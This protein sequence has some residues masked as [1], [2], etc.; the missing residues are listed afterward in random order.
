MPQR[1]P[2]GHA[3][4]LHGRGPR[5]Y[6]PVARRLRRIL[7]DSNA[8]SAADVTPRWYC[9]AQAARP[10][11]R[12]RAVAASAA[13]SAAQDERCPVQRAPDSALLKD[14]HR[15]VAGAHA[16]RFARFPAT[17]PKNATADATQWSLPHRR[18]RTAS[19]SSKRF[20]GNWPTTLWRAA[21]TPPPRPMF[22][23]VNVTPAYARLHVSLDS[24]RRTP[25]PLSCAEATRAEGAADEVRCARGASA[26]GRQQARRRLQRLVRWL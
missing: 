19:G 16:P 26:P 2:N 14:S 5:G 8:R 22:L 6:A 3:G 13:C 12:S 10:P 17:P 15:G 21:A 24:V 7:L 23:A 4:K 9:S 1:P 11:D 18:L 25:L 20:H